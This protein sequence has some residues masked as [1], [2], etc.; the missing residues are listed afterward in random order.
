MAAVHDVNDLIEQYHLAQGELF[1]GN[2]EPMK[3]LWSHR[4]D[5][6]LA[7]PWGPPVRGQEQVARTREHVA[8]QFRDGE[9]TSIENVAKYATSELVYIV[10]IEQAKAKIGGSED[11][12]PIAVRVTLILRPEDG[13][14]K[15]VHRHAAPKTT[16]RPAESVIQ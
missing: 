9:L 5:V 10:E 2:P 11:I 13:E 12:T 6:T 7:N 16:P 14:W 4:E 15:V 1:K 8:S 3:K